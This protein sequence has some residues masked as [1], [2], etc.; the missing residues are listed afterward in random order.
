M[1]DVSASQIQTQTVS[2][3]SRILV[4]RVISASRKEKVG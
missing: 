1:W 3:P 2:G 4:I